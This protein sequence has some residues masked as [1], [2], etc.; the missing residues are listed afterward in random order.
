VT[1]HPTA[2]VEVGTSRLG[3]RRRLS[4]PAAQLSLT[5]VM[6]VTVVSSWFITSASLSSL[7]YAF[8]L[9]AGASTA[10]LVAVQLGFAAGAGVS[11]ILRVADRVPPSRILPAAC[12]AVAV[13]DVVPIA[14]PSSPSLLIARTAVG[15]LLGVVYPIGMRAAVSW[16]SGRVRGLAVAAVVAALTLGSASPQLIRGL[17]DVPWDT[18]SVVAAALAIVGGG[19]ALLV[20]AGPHSAAP[21]RTTL[22]AAV[23]LLTDPAQVRVSLAYIGHMWETYAFWV[24]VPA[25][26]A[27]LPHP[28]NGRH[29]GFLAFAVIGLAGVVGCVGGGIVARVWSQRVVARGASAL[30]MLCAVSMLVAPMMPTPVLMSVLLLWGAAVI[31]DSAMYSAMTGGIAGS[32]PVGTAIAMQMA[33]GYAVTAAAVTCTSAIAAAT[34][35]P[36]AMALTATA[37]AVSV[38]LLGRGLQTHER[39]AGGE[40]AD[41]SECVVSAHQQT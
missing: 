13:I 18:A 12:A 4:V 28:P 36:V 15:V 29:I 16:F 5:V 20:D 31:A 3:A 38:A 2:G 39:P 17:G 27:A 25:L 1:E 8:A 33:V 9:P 6:L 34:S 35:W 24:W 30:S 7:Q 37:P 40:P 26:I 32:R 22:R 14:A 19:C 11:C 21:G 10:L 23:G 41:R